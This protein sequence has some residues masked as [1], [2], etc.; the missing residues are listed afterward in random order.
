MYLVSGLFDAKQ[1]LTKEETEDPQRLKFSPSSTELMDWDHLMSVL[2]SPALTLQLWPLFKAKVHT[3]SVLLLRLWAKSG[4]DPPQLV[5]V[6]SFIRILFFW[7][8][9]KKLDVI[10]S[11]NKKNAK[12]HTDQ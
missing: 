1:K 2:V 10:K 8:S 12:T 4:G 5:K 6:R 3:V 11:K 9:F 7:F